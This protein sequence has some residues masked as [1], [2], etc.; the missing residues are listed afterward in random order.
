MVP[1]LF[2]NRSGLGT[3][4]LASPILRRPEGLCWN[5]LAAAAK[6]CPKGPESSSICVFCSI[7]KKDDGRCRRAAHSTAVHTEWCCRRDDQDKR[8]VNGTGS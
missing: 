8:T 3:T 6:T 7:L 1:A 5:I 2:A 4:S